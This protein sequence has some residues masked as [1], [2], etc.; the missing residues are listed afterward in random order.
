MHGRLDQQ[1]Y[2]HRYN[3]NIGGGDDFPGSK[4]VYHWDGVE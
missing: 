1:S 4:R 2:I 3:Q